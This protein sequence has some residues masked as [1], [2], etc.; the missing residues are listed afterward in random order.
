MFKTISMIFIVIAM[1]SVSISA[2]IF[3]AEKLGTVRPAGVIIFY[4]LDSRYSNGESMRVLT[5]SISEYCEWNLNGVPAGTYSVSFYYKALNIRSQV[6]ASLDGSLLGPVIDM[7]NPTEI[8][9][10]PANL[11]LMSFSD[12]GYVKFRL[13]V[14]GRNSASTGF[15]MQIDKIVL[16]PV[17]SSADSISCRTMKVDGPMFCQKL[18]VNNWAIEA[19]DYVFAQDYNLRPLSDVEAYILKNSHLPE[20][21]SAKEIKNNGVDVQEMNMTLLKKIEELTLYVIDQDKKIDRLQKLIH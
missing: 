12:Y 6:Q 19:P 8:Y 15:S 10:V 21:P 17:F 13:T 7:Y 4:E 5:D 20:V 16:T 2:Q 9:Q 14:T 18:L 1:L 3:E 11:G